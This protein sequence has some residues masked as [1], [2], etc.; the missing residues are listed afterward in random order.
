MWKR[1]PNVFM[2]Q[3]N[4]L[5][6]I[7]GT[8][9]WAREA[10]TC[11]CAIPNRATLPQEKEKS[12]P[13][14]EKYTRL[15]LPRFGLGTHDRQGLKDSPGREDLARIFHIDL[16]LTSK[17]RVRAPGLQAKERCL[18]GRVPSRGGRVCEICR[19]AACRS[20]RPVRAPGQQTPRCPGKSCRPGAP[21]R[22]FL[23]LFNRLLG[24]TSPNRKS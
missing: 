24:E 2:L 4:D 16:E 7:R 15:D 20:N 10:R 6:R 11:R 22:R 19:L 18:E 14:F 21:T 12:L 5:R 17:H 1:S 9:I 3:G 23:E 13:R 8:P